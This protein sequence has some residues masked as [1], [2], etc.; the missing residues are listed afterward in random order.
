LAS[1]FHAPALRA[2]AALAFVGAYISFFMPGRIKVGADGVVV[3]WYG[4]KRFIGYGDVDDMT[5]YARPF[6]MT[7]IRGVSL[8]LKSGEEIRVPLGYGYWDSGR[9][10]IVAE[11]IAEAMDT[12]RRGGT[13][14]EAAML[15]RGSRKVSEWVLALRQ[16]G[17]GASAGPRTAAVA[18]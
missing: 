5:A 14:S 9:S 1:F 11:R 15:N 18:H 13:G 16:L 3:S 2:G 12:Y 7:E 8:R 10:H 6:G 17:S 4:I